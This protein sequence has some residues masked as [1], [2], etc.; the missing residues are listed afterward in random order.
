MRYAL[1][2]RYEDGRTLDV[3]LVSLSPT[4]ALKLMAAIGACIHAEDTFTAV[5][6]KYRSQNVYVGLV[7][8]E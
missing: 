2:A 4:D 7:G 8:V 5:K 1:Y 3:G 6:I